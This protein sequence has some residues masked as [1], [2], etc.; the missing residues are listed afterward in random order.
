MVFFRVLL[1]AVRTTAADPAAVGSPWAVAVASRL[2][3][4]T[5]ANPIPKG[6]FLILPPYLVRPH[7]PK[8][9]A[10][11]GSPSMGRS[12]YLWTSRDSAYSASR[13]VRGLRPARCRGGRAEAVP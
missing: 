3:S 13:S 8:G 6:T 10:W 1:N 9:C 11:P 2:D 12:A 7:A 5:T 4:T